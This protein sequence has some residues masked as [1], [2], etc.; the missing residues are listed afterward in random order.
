MK[1]AT[2]STTLILAAAAVAWAAQGV[3]F[4]DKAGNMRIEALASWRI[5]REAQEKYRFSGS[6]SPFV[7]RWRDRGL[8]VRATSLDGLAQRDDKGALRLEEATFAG[9]VRAEVMSKGR[10]GSERRSELTSPRVEYTRSTNRAVVQGPLVLISRAQGGREIGKLTGSRATLTLSPQESTDTW[11]IRSGVIEG[12]VTATLDVA[13]DGA[14]GAQ[15]MTAR[16]DRMEFD[17]EGRRL[18]LVGNV[19]ITGADEATGGSVTGVQRA[20]IR[21]N[22]AREVTEIEF[23]GSPGVTRYKEKSPRAAG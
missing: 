13:G 21:F 19:R 16:A 23:I 6:G 1:L 7:G 4:E 14:R 22:D 17:D 5:A 11:P 12:P 3:V 8:V 18:D 10:D 20:R 9:S 15:S 2:R